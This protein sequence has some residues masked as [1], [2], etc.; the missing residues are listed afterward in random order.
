MSDT[1]KSSFEFTNNP[2]VEELRSEVQSLRMILACSLLLVFIFSLCV[3]IFLLHQ[4]SAINGQLAQATKTLND[5]AAGGPAQ[6]QAIDF[7]SKLN[8]YARTHP[9]FAPIITKYNQYINIHPNPTA[10]VK[11]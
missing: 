10:P 4:T 8:D 2:G 3:N 9:D 7:W 6:G 11:K 1:E 5:W